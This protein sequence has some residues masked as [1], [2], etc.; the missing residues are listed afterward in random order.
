MGSAEAF[1]VHICRRKL[2][3]AREHSLAD[4]ASQFESLMP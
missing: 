1:V 2:N 4:T 3:E